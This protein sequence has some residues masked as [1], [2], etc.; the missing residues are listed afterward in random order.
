MYL[1]TFFGA[2]IGVWIPAFF[3]RSHGMEAGELGTWLAFTWGFGGLFFTFLGGFL[4]TRYAARQEC[5]QMK[6]VTVLLVLSAVFHILCY[7]STNKYLALLF[8]S[9]V[10]GGFMPL[11]GA[12]IYASIQSLV[13]GQMRAVAFAFIFMLSNLIGLGLGPVAVGVISDTLSP[14]FGQESLRYALLLFSPGYLW[15]AF[16][17]WKAANTIEEEIRSVESKADS[18]ETRAAALEPAVSTGLSTAG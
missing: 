5:L 8:V 17:C 9:I 6:A 18:M 15:C 12:T 10:A 7:L 14:S 4:A 1:S 13:E 2:G 11:M 16:H 3:I